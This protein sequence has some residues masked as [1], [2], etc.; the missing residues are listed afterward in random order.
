MIH[1]LMPLLCLTLSLSTWCSAKPLPE[2]GIDFPIPETSFHI[3]PRMPE[4]PYTTRDLWLESQFIANWITPE[5]YAFRLLQLRFTPPDDNSE[6]TQRDLYD[7]ATPNFPKNNLDA[8]KDWL[9]TDTLTLIARDSYNLAKIYQV[10]TDDPTS[11]TYL[12]RTKDNRYVRNPWFLFEVSAPAPT[13]TA[14][15]QSHIANTI[16]SQVR[17]L[18]EHV[19]KP[20]PPQPTFLQRLLSRLTHHANWPIHA[21]GDTIL[22]TDLSADAAKTLFAEY[23]AQVLPVTR[24]MGRLVPPLTDQK[25]PRVLIRLIAND[26]R[27]AFYSGDT[28]GRSSG[29]FIPQR[30]VLVIHVNQGLL[31]SLPTL[32]HESFHQYLDA[33]WG[34]RPTS[35][36]F[37]EG[38]AVYFQYVSGDLEISQ[39][40]HYSTLI[41][42]NPDTFANYLPTLLTLDYTDFYAGGTQNYALAW[43]WIYLLRHTDYPQFTSIL[44]TYQDAIERGLTPQEATAE[45]TAHLTPDQIANRFRQFW[46]SDRI[47]ASQANPL[48]IH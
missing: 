45:A 4:Q 30:K 29:V 6:T 47:K 14:Q 36:W 10:P 27:Y 42:A 25:P 1:R 13:P 21:V 31:A 24:A 8:C 11:L 23:H 2:L 15:A 12:I 48:L 7:R 16:F 32:K 35:P 33:A 43:A 41:D 5:G 9:S 20:T 17:K 38:H 39:P 44:P 40:D 19:T 46:N 26:S 34:E 18:P 37:N 3:P 28:T 22:T